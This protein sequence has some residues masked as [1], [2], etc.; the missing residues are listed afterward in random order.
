MKV[1]VILPTYNE[2]E[3]IGELIQ[4][5]AGCIRSMGWAGE[6]IVVDD[7]SPDGTAAAA[8]TLPPQP[9][10]QVACYVR[11][12]VRGL[13]TAIRYGIERATGDCLVVMDTDFNHDPC[14][15]P[16]M[17]RELDQHDVIVGSR[18]IRGGGME[19]PV[20]NLLSGAYN[21][22]L[23]IFLGMPTNDNLSG[24]FAARKE[25]LDKMNKDVI[26]TGYGEYFMRLLYAAWKLGYRLHEVP[27]FYKLRQHGAS[28]SQF[29]HMLH[30][31]TLCAFEL[32]FKTPNLLR[33]RDKE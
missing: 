1:S 14:L 18:Y 21:L 9:G 22:L 4:A 12:G 6:I 33:L 20:R 2:V 27:V 19:D 32:R 26:F 23:R 17:V 7:N 25:C 31:Y 29:G 28:K 3:N 15:I 30:D 5:A 13:A 24:F 8:G 10:V 11:T 16:Q